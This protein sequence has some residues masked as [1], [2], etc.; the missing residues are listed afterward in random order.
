MTQ[1][2]SGS[3]NRSMLQDALVTVLRQQAG[4]Q[5]DPQA[6]L[7]QCRAEMLD[8]LAEA[9][10]PAEPA[11]SSIRLRMELAAAVDRASDIVQAV[12]R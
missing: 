11:I 2:D 8:F 10:M 4:G 6:W 12:E 5:A 1:R 9:R 3:S 7:D